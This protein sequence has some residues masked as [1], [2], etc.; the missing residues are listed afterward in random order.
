MHDVMKEGTPVIANV[1]LMNNGSKVPYMAAS[2]WKQGERVTETVM[3]VLANTQAHQED[4]E[5]Y[6]RFSEDIAFG[7]DNIGA[8]KESASSP[9]QRKSKRRSQSIEVNRRSF[10][11]KRSRLENFNVVPQRQFENTYSLEALKPTHPIQLGF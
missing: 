4:I 8:Q 11:P 5:K 10:S 1:R 9:E 3:E 2:V 6:V 7:L